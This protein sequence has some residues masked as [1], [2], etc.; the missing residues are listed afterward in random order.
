M[1]FNERVI[2]YLDAVRIL[3]M[4]EV[5]S[6]VD[7]ASRWFVFGSIVAGDGVPSDIDFLLVSSGM[8]LCQRMRNDLSSFLD[9]NPVDLTIMTWEEEAELKFVDGVGAVAL[10]G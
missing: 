8:E 6:R 4:M 1:G 3:E 10:N 7:P 2:K 9:A 5:S